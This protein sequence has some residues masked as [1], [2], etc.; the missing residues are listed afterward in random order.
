MPR[1]WTKTFK[2]CMMRCGNN[3]MLA[4]PNTRKLLP[5]SSSTMAP[6]TSSHRFK[7]VIVTIVSSPHKSDLIMVQLF[8]GNIGDSK[9][10]TLTHTSMF[11]A[12]SPTSLK[13]GDN[14][15]E[16]L[17]KMILNPMHKDSISMVFS[18][19]QTVK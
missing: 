12:A 7:R 8:F 19:K 11:L 3:Y 6:T 5:L 18:C 4:M 15:V 16:T 9:S 13:A 10:C 14:Y 1:R 17:A 2:Q